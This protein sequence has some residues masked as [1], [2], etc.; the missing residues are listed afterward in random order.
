MRVL[1]PGVL[2]PAFCPTCGAKRF[3]SAT[4]D[5]VGLL[6][7][8]DELR[9]ADMSME[10]YG[11]QYNSPAPL[12][13][14]LT[15]GTKRGR[16]SAHTCIA[17]EYSP[18]NACAEPRRTPQFFAQSAEPSAPTQRSPIWSVPFF[19]S[20]LSAFSSTRSAWRICLWSSGSFY[21]CY[22]CWGRRWGR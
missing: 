3:D 12:A 19:S 8:L 5:V 13:E 10:Q 6:L 7:H 17:G 11:A 16:S 14:L 1:S 4:A 22:Y 9:L 20:A 18:A 15:P 2:P 21:Y